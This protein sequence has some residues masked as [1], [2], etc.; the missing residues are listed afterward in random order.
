MPEVFMTREQEL[1]T[2]WRKEVANRLTN[3]EGIRSD[4]ASYR[5]ELKTLVT[6]ERDRRRDQ[7]DALTVQI[8]EAKASVKTL[9][10]VGA[11]IAMLISACWAVWDHL[12]RKP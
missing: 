8:V 5:L 9:R 11:G 3:L 4:I 1:E 10:W 2:E 12:V 7:I 6:D